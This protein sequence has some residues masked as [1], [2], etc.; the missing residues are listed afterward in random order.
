LICIEPTK[1]Y[2]YVQGEGLSQ[3]ITWAVSNVVWAT[4]REVICE[5]YRVCHAQHISEGN[6]ASAYPSKAFGFRILF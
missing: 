5:P 2:F 3:K 6:N 1:K 4:A